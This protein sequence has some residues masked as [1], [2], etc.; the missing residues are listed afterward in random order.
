MASLIEMIEICFLL[1][2]VIT[3]ERKRRN[4]LGAAK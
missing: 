1:V 3:L 2:I 4:T